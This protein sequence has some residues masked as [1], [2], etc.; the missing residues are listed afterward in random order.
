MTT[1]PPEHITPLQEAAAACFRNVHQ[2]IA[3]GQ[4]NNDS[5]MTGRLGLCLYY[6]QLHRT[7]NDGRFADTAIQL[8]EAVIEGNENAAQQLSGISLSTG[9]TGLGYMMELMKKGGY[10]DMEEADVM[11]LIDDQVMKMAMNEMIPRHLSDYLHG[12]MGILLYFLQRLHVN[13]ARQYALELAQA[14]CGNAVRTPEGAWMRN[15]VF[16]G[17]LPTDINLSLSHGNSGFL[18]LLIK[19]HEKNLAVD[20]LKELIE[21]MAIFLL[22][23]RLPQPGAGGALFPALLQPGGIKPEHITYRLAWCY[24]DL[25]IVLALYH[26]A[27]TLN[28]PEWTQLAHEL[29]AAALQRDDPE[30]AM[31]QDAHFCHGS[32]GIAWCCQKLYEVSGQEQYLA[33]RDNWLW[34]TIRLLEQ[35]LPAGYYA[36]KECDLLE[37]LTGVAL[38]LLGVLHPSK[39]EWEELFLL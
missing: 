13:E 6:L 3:A 33:A 19:L 21:Q 34:H 4:P 8:L 5:L 29:G 17:D 32:S 16:A 15:V 28:K 7:L 38:V 20:G 30:K 14:V 35:Q 24:G 37:G 31:V 39:P 10:V 18:L 27:K 2:A 26:A 22:N 36:G 12:A 11:E 25:N 9:S 1:V 23:Q